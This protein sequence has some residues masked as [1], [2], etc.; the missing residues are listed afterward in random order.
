MKI[1]ALREGF[2]Q[3]VK[4]FKIYKSQILKFWRFQIQ[5]L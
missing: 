1:Y 3:S 5:K 2:K 4:M